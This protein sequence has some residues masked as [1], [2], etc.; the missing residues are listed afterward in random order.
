MRPRRRT[1]PYV[2]LLLLGGVGCASVPET[3]V[4]VP[5]RYQD[6]DASLGVSGSGSKINLSLG[7]SL[8]DLLNRKK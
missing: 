7:Q 6:E 2:L 3:D 8:F 5:V 1:V 4:S